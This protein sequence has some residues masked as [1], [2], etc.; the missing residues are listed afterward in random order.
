M[1]QAIVKKIVKKPATSRTAAESVRADRFRAL[2][3]KGG[4]DKLQSRIDDAIRESDE[5]RKRLQKRGAVTVA[6][7]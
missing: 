4:A 2:A 7:S 5:R 3:V 1:T 6:V